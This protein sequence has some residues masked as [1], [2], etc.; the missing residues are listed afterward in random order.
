M[1]RTLLQ[2]S[3]MSIRGRRRPAR[4]WS[5]TEQSKSSRPR[6]SRLL[7]CGSHGEPNPISL[8]LRR[9][10]RSICGRHGSLLNLPLGWLLKERDSEHRIVSTL[11]RMC[12]RSNI[13]LGLHVLI[14]NLADDRERS[15]GNGHG[16]CLELFDGASPKR[17]PIGYNMNFC[18]IGCGL[19]LARNLA[20][21]CSVRESTRQKAIRKDAG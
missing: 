5:A 4:V 15:F 1:I 14:I 10:R 8:S 3:S 18:R 12:F 9:I 13:L 19:E 16:S 11:S 20:R 17:F 2:G 6:V 21:Q 7:R